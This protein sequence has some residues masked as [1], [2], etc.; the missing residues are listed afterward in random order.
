MTGVDCCGGSRNATFLGIVNVEREL[1]NVK[2]NSMFSSI[3]LAQVCI[4][5]DNQMQTV[6]QLLINCLLW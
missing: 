6:N 2:L 4:Y 3:A 5:H 1:L